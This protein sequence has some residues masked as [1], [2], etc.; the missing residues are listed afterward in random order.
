MATVSKM[1]LMIAMGL[2]TAQGLK[3]KH[4]SRVSATLSE[5]SEG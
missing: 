1:G 3:A 4:A 5:Q 2:L